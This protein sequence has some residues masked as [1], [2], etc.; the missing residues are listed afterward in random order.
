MLCREDIAW[1]ELPPMVVMHTAAAWQEG[2]AIRLAACCFDEVRALL[3]CGGHKMSS[4]GPEMSLRFGGMHTHVCTLARSSMCASHTQA[5]NQALLHPLEWVLGQADIW[6]MS[7]PPDNLT[8]STR[9][10]CMVVSC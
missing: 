2:P 3:S 10:L 8:Q 1:F 4:D 7:L 6:Y 5:R 9:H